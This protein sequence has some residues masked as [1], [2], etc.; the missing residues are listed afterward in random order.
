MTVWAADWEVHLDKQC[1]IY[2][3]GQVN[4]EWHHNYRTELTATS[5]KRPDKSGTDRQNTR[6]LAFVAPVK[7][8]HKTLELCR[9]QR[10]VNSF[11]CC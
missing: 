11:K 8:R 3:K 7:K 2:S 10:S 9:C 4:I 1:M 6:G 5:C